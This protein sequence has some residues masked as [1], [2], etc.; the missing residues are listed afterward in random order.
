M[1]ENKHNPA[2]RIIN[3]L[4]LAETAFKNGDD[5][6]AKELVYGSLK[7]LTD[8]YSTKKDYTSVHYQPD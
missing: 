2:R 5:K 6:V 4:Y 7:E 3:G 1:D 8:E